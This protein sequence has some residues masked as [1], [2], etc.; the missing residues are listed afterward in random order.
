MRKYAHISPE[1]RQKVLDEVNTI[2]E[3]LSST[4]TSLDRQPKTQNPSVT[5]ANIVAKKDALDKFSAPI[6]NKPKPA[7]PKVEE[8]KPDVPNPAKSPSPSP[9]QPA[10]GPAPGADTAAGAAPK[11]DTSA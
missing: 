7:P 4:L 3:W 2:D 11:M 9:E 10:A 6:V 5:V 1:D 8:K